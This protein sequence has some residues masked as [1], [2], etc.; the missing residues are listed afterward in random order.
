MRMAAQTM[1]A[2][3]MRRRKSG[4]QQLEGTGNSRGSLAK[5]NRGRGEAA[6]LPASS[7]G[8]GGLQE[9]TLEQSG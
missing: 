8:S 3:L 2:K 7:C 4:K 6:V 5:E 1:N 9:D